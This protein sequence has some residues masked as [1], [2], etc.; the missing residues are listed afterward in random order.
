MNKK[1]LEMREQ[2]RKAIIEALENRYN[3]YYCDLHDEIFNTD[4]YIIGTYEAKKVLEEYDVWEAIEKV[5]QYEEDNFDKVYTDLAN[6][7]KIAN[8]LWYIIGEETLIELVEKSQTLSDNW[9]NL[10]TEKT[11]NQIL[12]EIREG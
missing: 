3:G 11:N 7:E 9:D 6:P 8:M 10:A 2:A 4:Y 1:E 12:K 5:Q